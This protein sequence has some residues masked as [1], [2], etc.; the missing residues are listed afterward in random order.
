[1]NNCACCGYEPTT[2]GSTAGQLQDKS[3]LEA[4]ETA[5]VLWE[6]GPGGGG[7]PRAGGSHGKGTGGSGKA[8]GGAP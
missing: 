3:Y 4:R 1:M 6:R 2:G 8:A 5:L 7:G